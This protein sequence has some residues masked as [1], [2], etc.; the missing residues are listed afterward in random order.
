[1]LQNLANCV[2]LIKIDGGSNPQLFA[3]W[4]NLLR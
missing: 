2:V 4:V 3:Y 1:M